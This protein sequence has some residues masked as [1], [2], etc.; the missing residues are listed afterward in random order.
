MLNSYGWIEVICNRLFSAE[1]GF[2]D[3][4]IQELN[5]KNSRIKMKPYMGFIHMGVRY[6]PLIY[7]IRGRMIKDLPSLAFQLLEEARILTSDVEKF[8][9]DK[10][11]IRQVLFKLLHQAKDKQEIR[12]A[13][14]E[15]IIPL[16]P[17]FQNMQRKMADPTFMIKSDHRAMRDYEA[18]LPKIEFYSV[19]RMIY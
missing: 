5:E 2:M 15:C 8:E 16:M 12:D 14:P 19:S 9:K 13:L 4:R 17:E 11:K 3:K 18:I 10:T 1:E 6:V 7:Q